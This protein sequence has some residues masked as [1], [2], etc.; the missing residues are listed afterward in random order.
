MWIGDV[1]ESAL[2]L[3]L[4]VVPYTFA[5]SVLEARGGRPRFARSA[6][7]AVTLQF[8]LAALASAA[9]L[10]LLITLD[11]H[12]AYVAGY[13]SKGLELIYRIAAFWGGDQGS[14]LFWLLVMT[15]YAFVV[16]FTRHE[17]SGRMLPVVTAILSFVTMFFVAV[18]RFAADPFVRLA[19]APANGSGLNALL[20]NPGM[21]VHPVNLY[22]GYVGFIVPFAY[23][24][25]GLI[26][27]KTDATWLRV[28]R[29]WTLISWLFLSCGIIYG[30]HWSYE[31][32]GW[33]GFWAWDPIENA[34]LMP[35]LAATAF[36]HS[37]VVQEKKG[38]LRVW[39]VSLISLTYLLTLFGTA[40]TRGGLLWSIHAFANGPLG[41]VFM[42]FV[43][44]MTILTAGLIAWRLPV[45]RGAARLESPVSRESGF[46][47]NNV[48]FIGALF[49]VFWG[50]VFPIVSGVVTGNE[51]QVSGPFYDSVVLP[52][53]A[54]IL[55]LMGIGPALAWRRADPRRLRAALFWPAVL[56]VAAGTASYAAGYR[57]ILALVCDMAA[58]FVMGTVL[59]EFWTG[60]RARAA[61]TGEGAAR[62]LVRLVS[63]NR[64][65]Y[66]GYIVHLAVVIMALGFAGTGAYGQQVAASLKVGQTISLGGYDLTFHGLR[67]VT[68]PDGRVLLQGVMVV[69][70]A[71]SGRALGVLEPNVE[72]FVSGDQPTANLG[73][74][75][76]PLADLYVVL[77]GSDY[78][79][80]QSL[81]EV[82]L[83]PL[84]GFIWWG[85]YLYII[86]TFISLWPEGR[87]LRR[88]EAAERA[89]R[90]R[91]AESIL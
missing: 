67:T 23:A 8:G 24:M 58:V 40:L 47:L 86:G 4:F 56:A 12:Y 84:V 82:H 76:T 60:V 90:Q 36:L 55:L 35:W 69:T 45:L 51:M 33:G 65:R 49:A 27:K 19:Q 7:L 91:V 78:R 37:A 68:E 26:L 39:N 77:D 11:F 66:G 9:L 64:R 70:N 74:Y 73:L 48:L 50:T 43:G 1:G 87:R 16:R 72:F 20:Q 28:T 15:L 59:R 21:T 54:G 17:D 63:K 31:E 81:F 10:Y 52:I 71:Q 14:L 2:T 62:S 32:L 88:A 83:N 42:D 34:A 85:G 53:G 38:M 57:N 25:A 61:L 3:L 80:G 13:T 79:T 89:A 46:L 44:L 22:L 18:L 30:A 29:K 6:R 5:A 75:S 41:S